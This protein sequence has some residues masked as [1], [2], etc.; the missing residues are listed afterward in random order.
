VSLSPGAARQRSRAGWIIVGEF[1]RDGFYYQ[2]VRRPIGSTPPGARLTKREEQVLKH[3]AAGQNNKSIAHTLGLSPST[4]GVLLFRAA[5]KLGVKSRLELL[6]AYLR[7]T[8][9]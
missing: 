1:V 9:G 2:I 8:R 7:L 6:A 4:V 5:A 3:A